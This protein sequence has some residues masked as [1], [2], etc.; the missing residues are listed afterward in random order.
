MGTRILVLVC[1]A[2]LLLV[3]ID[4]AQYGSFG[5]IGGLFVLVM[6]FGVRRIN[7]S[8]GDA[9]VGYAILMAMIALFGAHFRDPIRLFAAIAAGIGIVWI[10]AMLVQRHNRRQ[11]QRRP[12]PQEP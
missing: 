8:A 1:V 3:A 10:I 4:P 6:S 11:N 9:L 5:W 2:Y 12:Q 7:K